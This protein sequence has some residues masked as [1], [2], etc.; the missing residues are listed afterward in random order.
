MGYHNGLIFV[1]NSKYYGNGL[2]EEKM[3]SCSCPLPPLL[4]VSF[5]PVSP[6]LKH[7]HNLHSGSCRPWGHGGDTR[8]GGQPPVLAAGREH[9]SHVVLPLLLHRGQQCVFRVSTWLH[10]HARSVRDT[11]HHTTPHHTTSLLLDGGKD[12]GKRRAKLIATVTVTFSL[13]VESR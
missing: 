12:L 2:C 9:Q 4:Y 11:P 5:V 10:L 3:Y 7:T 1:V 8:F 13:A 6:S